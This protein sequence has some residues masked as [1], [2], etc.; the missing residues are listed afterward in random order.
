MVEKGYVRELRGTLAGSKLKQR[1]SS[2]ET[3][4]KASDQASFPSTNKKRCS[5][6]ISEGS[7]AFLSSSIFS[8]T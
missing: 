6:I 3:T 5:M 8:V 1:V 7:L 4:V 2:Q